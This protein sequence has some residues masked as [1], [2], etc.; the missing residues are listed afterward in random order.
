METEKTLRDRAIG[1]A[2]Y[3]LDCSE[4]EQTPEDAKVLARYA[5]LAINRIVEIEKFDREEVFRAG[6]QFAWGDLR[7]EEAADYRREDAAWDDYA[8][9][10]SRGA[11]TREPAPALPV[12]G[13][14][15]SIYDHERA[16]DMKGWPDGKI[17][18][19]EP[20]GTFR[21]SS[22]PR[23]YEVTR[24]K[25]LG[26]PSPEAGSGR[27]DAPTE[28][29]EAPRGCWV[30]FGFDGKPVGLCTEPERQRRFPELKMEAVPM[31]EVLPGQDGADERAKI[32]LDAKNRWADRARAAEERARYAE[33]AH[34]T[35]LDEMA[36]Q[37]KRAVA[38]EAR[39]RELETKLEHEMSALDWMRAQVKALGVDGAEDWGPLYCSRVL[40]M[41][42]KHPS[43]K[44]PQ[45]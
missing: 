33:A 15:C 42:I 24:R 22:S 18:E 3:W 14:T 12:T 30:L 21:A 25:D 2:A 32:L 7:E 43:P 36:T 1:A 6:Y 31:R 20:D 40:A 16:F 5:R 35:V 41:H 10:F 26:E 23:F 34:Q 4:H 17:V 39:V 37:R 19:L 45:P 27:E 13:P 29:G 38:A 28:P 11:P 9:R 8:K 44:E